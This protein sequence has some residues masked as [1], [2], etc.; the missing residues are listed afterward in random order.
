MNGDTE[1]KER[2]LYPFEIK[3]EERRSGT[4]EERTGGKNSRR[5]GVLAKRS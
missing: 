3:K 5:G 1:R 2:R 4:D